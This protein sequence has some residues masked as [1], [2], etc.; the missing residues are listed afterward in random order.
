MQNF[1]DNWQFKMEHEETWKQVKIPHDWLIADTK[2]LYKT[3]VGCYRKTFDVKQLGQKF[4]LRFDGIYMDA[5]LHING[6]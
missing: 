6:Q 3:G 5:T 4:F 2:N 1:N